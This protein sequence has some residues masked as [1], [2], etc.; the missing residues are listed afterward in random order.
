MVDALVVEVIYAL[1]G[2]QEIIRVQLPGG[3]CVREAVEASGMLQKFPDIDPALTRVGIFGK[4]V[5]W[6]TLLTNRD[7]VEIYR[8]LLCD[9][10]EMRRER[11]NRDRDRRKT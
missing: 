4:L 8:P 1:P 5:D 11:V 7:R 2:H 10:K 9:P 3:S 6:K